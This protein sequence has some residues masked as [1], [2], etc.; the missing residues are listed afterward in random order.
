[1][2]QPSAKETRKFIS[3]LLKTCAQAKVKGYDDIKSQ[4]ISDLNS[5]S[6]DISLIR[7]ENNDT[8]GILAVIEDKIDTVRIIIDSYLHILGSTEQFFNWVFEYNKDKANVFDVA[9]ER[10][11]INIIQYLFVILSKTS[12]VRLELKEPNKKI[13]YFILL[14]S[15]TNAI[16]LYS[17]MKNYKVISKKHL[18]SIHRMK[19]ELLRYYMHQRKQTSNGLITRFRSEYQF[20]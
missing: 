14:L 3:T 4:V 15:I 10:G 12:E 13:I 2:S 7:S 11:N 20:G 18:S 16:L 8:L 6:K 9:A 17:S 5:F 1:M 19:M